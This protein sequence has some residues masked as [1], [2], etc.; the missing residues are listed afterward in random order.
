MNAP[1][2]ALAAVALINFERRRSGNGR[3]RSA[4]GTGHLE[5]VASAGHAVQLGD[6]QSA[7]GIAIAVLARVWK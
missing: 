1:R 5:Q 4:V 6:R 3:L 2:L 7:L